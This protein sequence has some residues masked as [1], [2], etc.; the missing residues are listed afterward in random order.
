MFNEVKKNTLVM[1]KNRNAREIQSSYQ[2]PTITDVL[3]TSKMRTR[4]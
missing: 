2:Y 1:N 3:M 4:K